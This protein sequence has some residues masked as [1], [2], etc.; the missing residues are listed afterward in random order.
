MEVEIDL[1]AFRSLEK[2]QLLLVDA[3]KKVNDVHLNLRLLATETGLPFSTVWDQWQKMKSKCKM[4]LVIE[5]LS[6]EER[7]RGTEDG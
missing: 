5:S 3:M 2:R 4:K 1:E 7:L 6:A